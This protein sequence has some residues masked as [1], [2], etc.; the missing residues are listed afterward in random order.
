MASPATKRRK[1]GPDQE[2]EEITVVEYEED[3]ME[4]IL[5]QIKEQE[6]SEALA[7]QLEAE[8]NDSDDM[9]STSTKNVKPNISNEDITIISDDGEEDDEA[10]ARRLAREWEEQDLIRNESPEPLLEAQSSSQSHPPTSWNRPAPRKSM[11][12]SETESPPDQKLQEFRSLFTQERN[13]PKC[14]KT[15]G[16]IRG[17]VCPITLRAN[18]LIK[19]IFG[20]RSFSLLV[21]HLRRY[22]KPILRNVSVLIA[23]G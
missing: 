14:N 8:W 11:L 3:D 12:Q 1:L 22:C 16:P 17:Q 6:D 21:C 23:K 19:S 13:C 18:G 7:R 4:A 10:M 20:G 2:F 5:A 9:P 15:I